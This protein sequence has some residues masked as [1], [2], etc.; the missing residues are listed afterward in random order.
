MWLL[1]TGA[2]NHI[3]YNDT[4]LQN[5]R[6]LEAPIMLRV[7]NGATEAV[8]IIGDVYLDTILE[9][10]QLSKLELRNVHLIKSAPA[11]LL[12]ISLAANSGIDMIVSADGSARLSEQGQPLIDAFQ[13]GVYMFPATPR[14]PEGRVGGAAA[15]P[16]A[17][18]AL[19]A[20]NSGE[21]ELLWHRRFGHLGYGNMNKLVKGNMV[22]GLNINGFTNTDSVCEPCVM[23]KQHRHPFGTSEGKTTEPMQLVHMDVMGPLLTAQPGGNK[24]VT[25]PTVGPRI[26]HSFVMCEM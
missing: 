14:V 5:K 26:T 6:Y 2:A 25:L 20:S 18:S 21:A 23:A 1:D 16:M 24:Y 10:G 7:A 9:S 15:A 22:T 12:S 13:Q 3:T 17:A 11:N 8:T 19:T 4:I